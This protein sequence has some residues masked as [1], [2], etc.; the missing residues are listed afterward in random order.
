MRTD[1]AEPTRPRL[2]TAAFRPAV[3]PGAPTAG[4]VDGRFAA[5]IDSKPWRPRSSREMGVACWRRSDSLRWSVLPCS[6]PLWPWPLRCPPQRLTPTA[7]HRPPTP[8]TAAPGVPPIRDAS[9]PQSTPH[10]SPPPL[11]G[12]QVTPPASSTS[13]TPWL[14]PPDRTADR[15]PSWRTLATIPRHQSPPLQHRHRSPRRPSTPPPVPPRSLPP[16]PLPRPRNR[17]SPPPC[18]RAARLPRPRRRLRMRS[19]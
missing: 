7:R 11:A 3:Y 17:P 16:P 19:L 18:R 13:P 12:A 15:S 2:A 6:P 10:R 5:R 4:R 1:V 8:A 14:H 9:R